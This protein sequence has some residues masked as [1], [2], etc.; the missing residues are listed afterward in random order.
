LDKLY[1]ISPAEIWSVKL[2]E[3]LGGLAAIG[4][5]AFGRCAAFLCGSSSHLFSL[6]T[7][8]GKTESELVA[9]YPLLAHAPDLNETKFSAVR[10]PISPPIDLTTV[11]SILY[12]G[13]VTD[14]MDNNVRKIIRFVAFF[15]GAV[16][17]RVVLFDLAF[18]D[19]S[20]SIFKIAP[21]PRSKYYHV[22]EEILNLLYEKNK[23]LIKELLQEKSKVIED[24][25][26]ASFDGPNP[27]FTFD[28]PTYYQGSIDF[29]KVKSINWEDRF[30]PI[31]Y[32][33]LVSSWIKKYPEDTMIYNAVD[34]L[35]D[36]NFI[37]RLSASHMSVDYLYPYTMYM[38]V[39]HKLK[40]EYPEVGYLKSFIKRSVEELEG[41]LRG[42]AT[43]KITK[44][45]FASLRQL[46]PN[47]D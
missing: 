4:N 35:C 12:G 46:F 17:R 44:N 39:N 45:V 42:Q 21:L 10:L 28:N 7:A 20:V 11:L 33:E 38:L 24:N 36:E 25:E 22:W 34:T 6:I 23:D 27:Q 2:K 14:I 8:K 16:A 29:E 30:K 15:T 3:T 13:P 37:V 18:K 19:A 47:I 32:G 5:S 9:K 41:K 26:Y 31:T 1:E 43:D 40:D